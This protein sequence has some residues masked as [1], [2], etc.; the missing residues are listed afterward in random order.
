MSDDPDASE[1]GDG[2]TQDEGTQDIATLVERAEGDVLT[3]LRALVLDESVEEAETALEDLRQVALEAEELLETVNLSELPEAINVEELPDIVDVESIPDAVA[4]GDPTDAIESRELLDV[5]ELGKLWSTVD[6]REFWRNKDEFET[7]LEEA[8]GEDIDDDESR[9]SRL[10]SAFDDAMDGAG[11][12]MMDGDDDGDFA[13]IPDDTNTEAFQAAIQ[14]GLRDAVDEFRK[15]LLETHDRLK[16][17]REE[18]QERTGRA[19]QPDSRNPTAYSTLASASSGPSVGRGT[20]Y[21][22]VPRET[23]YSTAPNRKRIYGDRFEDA[24]AREGGDD[25]E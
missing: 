5:V 13:S 4:S 21:S 15:G 14:S 25:D 7:A 18:N 19:T 12:G 24:D 3:F 16:T 11:E 22:T 17:L 2:G 8:L 10:Q 9:L 6:V 20:R 23:K 1:A